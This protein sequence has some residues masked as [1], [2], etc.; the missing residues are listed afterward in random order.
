MCPPVPVA[1]RARMPAGALTG[2]EGKINTPRYY[3]TMNRV[4]R[5]ALGEHA[6]SVARDAL[7]LLVDDLG[8]HFVL[9]G[10]ARHGAAV[11]EQRG[12]AGHAG[13]LAGGEVGL[14]RGL[15]LA[16]I[17]APSETLRVHPELT[18]RG[19]ERVDLER[20]LPVVHAV[21]QLP[22]LVLFARAQ[23][24]FRGLGRLGVRG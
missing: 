13:L 4:S 6:R 11:H 19:L 5:M 10:A 20:F 8:E 15:V 22:E 18:R 21:V 17:E 3:R 23:R 2:A 7:E 24:G 14:D 16:G 9:D 1:L 12:R